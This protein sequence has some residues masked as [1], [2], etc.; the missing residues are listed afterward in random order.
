M[1]S[2]QIEI[3]NHLANRLDRIAE[4]RRTSREAL[5]RDLLAGVVDRE[6]ERVASELRRMQMRR[7]GTWRYGG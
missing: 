7:Q 5:A 6:T 1:A 3:P 2:I 4:E